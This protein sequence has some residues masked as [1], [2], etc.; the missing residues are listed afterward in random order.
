MPLADNDGI[1]IGYEV[2]GDEDADETVVFVSG[3]GYGRWFWNWQLPAVEDDYRVI[4]WDLRGINDSDTPEGPYSM[5][6]MASDLEAVLEDAGVEEAHI[7]GISLGG[8]LTQRYA[9]DYDR[10]KSLVLMST[11]AGG[12]ERVDPAPEVADR[13]LNPPEDVSLRENIGY[14]MQPAFTDEFWENEE[15]IFNEI[16][17]Y[18]VNNPVPDHVRGWQAAGVAA[19]DITDELDQVTVPVLIL[20]GERDK[21]VPVE[22]S[23]RL[24]DLLPQA[25]VERYD[26]GGSHLFVIE[27]AEDV[28]ERIR[29][30][31][32]SV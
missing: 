5:E 28:N 10:A 27:R 12:D 2:T 1:T 16:L 25:E 17:D 30:F 20:H 22:N 13:I 21:V 11:D 6:E 26:E 14:K 32:D 15:G 19:F 18:R 23:E 7:I 4:L 3:L 24:A 8:M 31:L 29:E 9:V